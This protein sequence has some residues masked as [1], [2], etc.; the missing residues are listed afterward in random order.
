MGPSAPSPEVA[1]AA[2]R[3]IADAS[4][5]SDVPE[6]LERLDEIER[7]WRDALS[8][9]VA[10]QPLEAAH[11]VERAGEVL[12]QLGRLD[13]VAE[14][15]APT[16]V[17]AFAERMQRLSRLHRELVAASRSAQATVGRTLGEARHGRTA[18]RAYGNE[19][20]ADHACDRIV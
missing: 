19:G 4:R 16:A 14:L 7:R 5:V 1:A 20:E 6:V 15:L 18:L 9:V 10:D 13:G 3:D 17:A 8:L 12:A 11:E 2:S